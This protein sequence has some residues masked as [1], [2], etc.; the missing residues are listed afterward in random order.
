MSRKLRNK[1]KQLSKEEFGVSAHTLG[2]QQFSQLIKVLQ[3]KSGKRD[4]TSRASAAGVC[5]AWPGFDG[6]SGYVYNYSGIFYYNVENAGNDWTD[7]P[8]D[9][10]YKFD[11]HYNRH[12]G[13]NQ[14]D[15]NIIDESL[16]LWYQYYSDGF[17]TFTLVG[18]I[19]IH[20]YYWSKSQLNM[21]MF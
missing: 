18:G 1:I 10:N 7:L 19:S 4:K 20:W 17:D 9:G 2:K 14:I 21:R 8:C 13:A 5:P 12:S 11:G 15:R 6:T 16:G 3:E